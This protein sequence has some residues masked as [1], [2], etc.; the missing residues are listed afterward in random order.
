MKVS[1]EFGDRL[2]CVELLSQDPSVDWNTRDQAGDTPLLCCLKN[3]RIGL[4]KILLDNPRVNLVNLNYPEVSLL[5]ILMLI[6]TF[7]ISVLSNLQGEDDGAS[8]RV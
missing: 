2:R 5:V 4:A 1:E 3:N 8:P 6:M 7:N